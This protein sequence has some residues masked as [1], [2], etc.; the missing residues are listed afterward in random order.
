MDET[1]Q[2]DTIEQPLL[3]GETYKVINLKSKEIII[4][5]FVIFQ[6]YKN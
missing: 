2:L 5:S 3:I 1:I 6:G 4:P